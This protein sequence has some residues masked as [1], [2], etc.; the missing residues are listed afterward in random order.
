MKPTS[1]QIR[2]IDTILDIVQSWANGD[3][4]DSPSHYTYM[5]EELYSNLEE[6]MRNNQISYLEN[7][8]SKLLDRVQKNK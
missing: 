7:E 5:E 8:L 6:Y 3:D 1:I 2:I 4:I